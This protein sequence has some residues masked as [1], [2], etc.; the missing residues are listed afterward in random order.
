MAEAKARCDIQRE[1]LVKT[2]RYQYS[3]TPSQYQLLFSTLQPEI[4]YTMMMTKPMSK[5]IMCRSTKSLMSP[6]EGHC[7]VSAGRATMAGSNIKFYEDNK[8]QEAQ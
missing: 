6:V 5:M 3:D 7:N 4:T 8:D 2:N 1:N